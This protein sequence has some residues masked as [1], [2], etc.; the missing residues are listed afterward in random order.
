M[1]DISALNSFL[2]IAIYVL[3][4]IQILCGIALLGVVIMKK[5]NEAVY[6][7]RMEVLERST[8]EYDSLPSYDTM[9]MK[10]WIPLHKFKGSNNG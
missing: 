5:R 7:F 2:T 10:F 9:M 1:E 3:I 8:Y 6:R 4:S